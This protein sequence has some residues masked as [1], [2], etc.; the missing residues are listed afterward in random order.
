[1]ASGQTP[2]AW[3][4]RGMH[5]GLRFVADTLVV[6]CRAD[7]EPGRMEW[8]QRGSLES[9]YEKC[10]RWRGRRWEGLPRTERGGLISESRGPLRSSPFLS[11]PSALKAGDSF[12]VSVCCW[13]GARPLERGAT[14]IT[15]APAAF[16]CRPSSLC[17]L[18]H[19]E[20]EHGPEL[21]GRL[22]SPVRAQRRGQGP[23][24]RLRSRRQTCTPALIL[25]FLFC[26][27]HQNEQ[28]SVS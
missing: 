27:S 17:S 4:Q 1:M 22:W 6:E 15:A 23:R 9:G 8:D 14:P 12:Y 3:A 19:T 18:P 10:A 16:Y 20:S 13:S 2:R 7:L 24:P 25:A 5:P 11:A 21:G 26:D 28:T